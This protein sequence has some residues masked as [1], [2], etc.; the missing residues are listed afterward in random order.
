VKVIDFTFN[1][2]DLAGKEI[3]DANSRC[4]SFLNNLVFHELKNE[5]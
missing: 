4:K 5:K 2:I 1:I 3:Q